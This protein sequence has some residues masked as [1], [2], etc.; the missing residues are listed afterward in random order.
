MAIQDTDLFVVQR[1]DTGTFKLTGAAL[2][3]EMSNNSGSVNLDGETLSVVC[4]RGSSATCNRNMSVNGQLFVNSGG[5]DTSIGS[6]GISSQGDIGCSG[7]ISGKFGGFTN[8]LNVGGNLNYATADN[9]SGA[10][11]IASDGAI[12]NQKALSLT[13]SG[14]SVKQLYMRVSPNTGLICTP[15]GRS[16]EEVAASTPVDTTDFCQLLANVQLVRYEDGEI[17]LR[18]DTLNNDE[19]SRFLADGS[20][21]LNERRIPFYL[22]AV[23]KKQQELIENLSTRVAQ[24]EA[25][26]AQAMSNMNNNG[27]Y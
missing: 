11:V 24:L 17:E 6:F 25:E 23:C 8:S 26:H 19:R 15:Q 4:N 12:Y 14:S 16:A 20:E 5:T 18:P 2:K 1:P 13:I 27:G 22:A 10:S 7:T 21:D 3:T 9:G